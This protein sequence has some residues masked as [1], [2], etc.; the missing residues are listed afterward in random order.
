MRI[1]ASCFILAG[2]IACNSQSTNQA[3]LND[4]VTGQKTVDQ[5]ASFSEDLAFLKKYHKDLVVLGDVD[6]KSQLVITPAYQGRVMTSTAGSNGMSFG[7]INRELIASGKKA[8]HI[9]AVGGEERFWLGP[10]G[11]QFGLYFKKGSSFDFNH[12]QVPKE[13]DTEPFNLVSAN[14]SEA[15]FEKQMHLENF[16]GTP[17]DI[18][19]ERSIKLLDSSAVASALG[20]AIPPGLS[21]VGFESENRIT[22]KGEEKWTQKS[23]LISIWILSMLNAS[24][25]TTVAI[26]YKKD[27]SES[28]GKIVTDDYFGKV[29]PERLRISN[30]LVLFKADAG[31]RS[32]IGISPSRALPVAGSYD[33]INSVLTIVQFSLTGSKDYVN[34]L[35]ELQQYPFAGDAVNAYNDG[36]IDGKQMGKFYELES[37]SA[38]AALAPGET[39][40]HMHRTM[41]FKGDKNNLEQIAVKL[42]GWSIDAI[43]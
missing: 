3:T 1:S 38:A 5:A 4:T 17:F 14:A 37:S 35:W 31:Y 20:M 21:V 23:G 27:D 11:G 9:N 40:R 42:L 10:E 43:K 28:L 24:P 39:L 15:K 41:H 19:V 34:S 22:N 32:K 2:M 8:E 16:S 36:P 13:L 33:A 29:P 26:P 30:D 25:Q 18:N 7:W 6:S 12:W